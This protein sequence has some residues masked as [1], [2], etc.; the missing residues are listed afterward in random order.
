[1]KS[2][3]T[4]DSVDGDGGGGVGV[5]QISKGPVQTQN[6]VRVKSESKQLSVISFETY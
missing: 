6:P 4:C 3:H 2:E 5:Y 1:M